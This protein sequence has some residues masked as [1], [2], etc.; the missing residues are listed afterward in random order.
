M[1]ILARRNLT[2][3]RPGDSIAPD[4]ASEEDQCQ[5]TIADT[6]KYLEQSKKILESRAECVLGRALQLG[7]AGALLQQLTA[8]FDRLKPAAL[9]A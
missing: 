9:N 6:R 8:A 5:K 7:N 1:S 3:A 2:S 4:E